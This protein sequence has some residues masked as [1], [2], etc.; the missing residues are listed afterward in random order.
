MSHLLTPLTDSALPLANRLVLPPM[1]T[2]KAEERHHRPSRSRLPRRKVAWPKD[3]GWA[4]RAVR[5]YAE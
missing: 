1:A 5:E 4:V 3:S 2:S